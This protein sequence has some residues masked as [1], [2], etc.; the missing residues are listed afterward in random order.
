VTVRVFSGDFLQAFVLLS[1]KVQSR[2]PVVQ[3]PI[4]LFCS[5]LR[6]WLELAKSKHRD[7]IRL[8]ESSQAWQTISVLETDDADGIHA[9]R[10][11]LVDGDHP[12]Q[13]G[14]TWRSRSENSHT[15]SFFLLFFLGVSGFW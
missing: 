15:C 2:T 4:W 7:S 9:S 5:K 1:R 6:K 12:G 10:C 3:G 13:N 11:V 8:L 14:S